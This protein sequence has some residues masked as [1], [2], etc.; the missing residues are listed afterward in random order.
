MP[1]RDT[2]PT[3]APCW[4]DLATSDPDASRSFYGR[5]FGWTSE[6]AGEEFGHYI[7]FTLDSVP[8]AGAMGN[9]A[10][11]ERPD[12]WSIYLASDDANKTVADAAANGGAV[13]LPAMPMAFVAD[14]GGATI[15]AWQP[16]EHKG[17]GVWDEP[18]TP[19][20]FELQTRDYAASVA[21]YQKVFGWHTSVASDTPELR[22]TTLGEG[23]GQLAGIMDGSGFLPEGVPAHW[24]VYFR[25]RNT[26]ATLERVEELG[27]RILLPAED[28]PY[29]RLAQ[30]AD[31]TG[32]IFRLVGWA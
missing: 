4:I 17:F 14:A 9:P 32:A 27:G 3:G 13:V 15:G 10:P 28:T 6:D 1:K 31:T 20:W 26:D 11:D 24:S 16:G 23:D 29:G 18:D 7:N 2:A 21:F 22:Y 8:V 25:V 12:G 30:A 19:G 5:L